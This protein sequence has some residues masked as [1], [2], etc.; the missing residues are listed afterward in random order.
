MFEMVVLYLVCF[1]IFVLM[2]IFLSLCRFLF[3]VFFWVYLLQTEFWFQVIGFLWVFVRFLKFFWVKINTFFFFK[4]VKIVI[5]E[6]L[7]LE[8]EGVLG[9]QS[10]T[11][12]LGQSWLGLRGIFYFQVVL[13]FFGI[14]YIIGKEK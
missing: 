10:L 2:D 13:D 14:E 6:T 7:V 5:Q 3:Y 1:E 4:V 9:V 8:V 12:E 11:V